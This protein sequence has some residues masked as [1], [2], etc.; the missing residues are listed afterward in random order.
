MILSNI[1]FFLILG[2]NNTISEYMRLT[3]FNN[4]IEEHNFHI[5]NENHLVHVFEN[6]VNNDKFIDQTNSEGLPYKLGHNA[7]SGYSFDEF[8]EIMSFDFNRNLIS[9]LKTNDSIDTIKLPVPLSVDWRYQ[10]VVNTIKDQGQCGSCWSFSTIQA[11][12]SASAI[13]YGKLYS[14]S[15]QELVDCDNFINHG[16]NGGL[17]DNAFTWIDKKN[18]ICSDTDYPYVSGVTKTAGMCQKTCK[19]QPN[20]DIIKYIDIIPNSDIEMMSALAQQPISVAI[21]ADQREFQLYSS[22]IFTGTCGTNIDHGVGLVGYS[23]DYYILRN[24]WGKS[25]GTN[26]Y[27]MIGKG[28]DPVTGKPY[29]NGAGQCGLLTTG[30]YPIV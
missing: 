13:K 2:V 27:M 1:I 22:G 25:W 30:S 17:M 21:E 9:S 6:W 20:T 5:F 12:E 10:G 11:L 29:N 7:Y 24:S 8:R 19:N 18:G 16:C 15:E 14:L 3:R 28:N 26:G 23:D 4:W